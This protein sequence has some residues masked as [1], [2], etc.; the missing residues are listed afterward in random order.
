MDS[1]EKILANTLI[2]Y[3]K[4][5]ITTIIALYSTRIVLNALGVEDYGIFTLVSSIV[6]MLSFISASLTVSTQRFMSYY[7]GVGNEKIIKDIFSTSLL[8]H[9]FISILII[10]ILFLLSPLIFDS[11]IQIPDERLST[12]KIVYYLT[13]FSVSTAIVAVPY[14]AVLNAHE[15]M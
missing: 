2:L 15:N 10:L 11:S 8:L 13:N 7:L 1:K 9:I 12:S 14:D 6:G 4:L 5:L 3:V